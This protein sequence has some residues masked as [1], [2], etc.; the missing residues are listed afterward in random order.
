[1]TTLAFLDDRTLLLSGGADKDVRNWSANRG[2]MRG[3]MHG[4]DAAVT[5][6][7]TQFL[8]SNKNNETTILVLTTT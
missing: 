1:V 8:K 5:I 4:H 2:D 3:K 6:E 7:C